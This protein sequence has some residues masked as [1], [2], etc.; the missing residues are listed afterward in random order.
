MFKKILIGYDGSDG[1]KK[2]LTKGI[3]IAKASG[4]EIYILSVGRIPEYA[5][6]ISEVEEAKEQAQKFYEKIQ[7]EA[8]DTAN[9]EGISCKTLIKYGKPGDVIVDT[10]T[11]IGA[12]L[13]IVGVHKHSAL[14]RRLLGATADKVVDNTTC[15]VL[16]VK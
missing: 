11:E 7:K 8:Y 1:A 5:E 15:S 12:D 2:A 6:I 3:E 13:I 16:V 9:K 4:A 10:A 14:K